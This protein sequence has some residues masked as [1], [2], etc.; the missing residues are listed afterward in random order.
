MLSQG[1][2]C[3]CQWLLQVLFL[4]RQLFTSSIPRGNSG[5]KSDA[6]AFLTKYRKGGEPP[7][8]AWLQLPAPTGMWPQRGGCGPSG[9]TTDRSIEVQNKTPTNTQLTDQGNLLFHTSR[10]PLERESNVD[11]DAGGIILLRGSLKARCHVV[12]GRASSDSQ[13]SKHSPQP[14]LLLANKK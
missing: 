7:H 12:V 1:R 2:E 3:G 6:D 14:E 10:A 5:S 4:V 11:W 9:T 8:T 13:D